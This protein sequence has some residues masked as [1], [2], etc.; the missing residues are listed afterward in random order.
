MTIYRSLHLGKP[1]RRRGIRYRTAATTLWGRGIHPRKG[2]ASAPLSPINAGAFSAAGTLRADSVHYR[3]LAF[4]G[5]PAVGE[6]RGL[7]GT[8]KGTLL[9][10]V[11]MGVTTWTFPQIGRA[12]V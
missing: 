12:H 2:R 10:S 8:L 1:P 4:P 3:S 9:E 11:P 6:K 5:I 7:Y